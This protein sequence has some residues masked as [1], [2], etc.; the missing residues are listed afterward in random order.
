M[1]FP[2]SNPGRVYIYVNTIMV[3]TQTVGT[4]G[5]NTG[6]S[7]RGSPMSSM[8]FKKRVFGGA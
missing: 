5:I 6:P 1:V 2:V 3:A 8:E 7:T 4:K